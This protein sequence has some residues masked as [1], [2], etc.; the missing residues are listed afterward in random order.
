MTGK[1]KKPG[2]Y[3]WERPE[4]KH[5]WFR[6]TV[7]TRYRHVVGVAKIQ[8]SLGTSNLVDARRERDKLKDELISKWRELAGE[9]PTVST[10]IA[11]TTPHRPTR[12][13]VAQLEEAA[14]A[15]GYDLYLHDASARRLSL[16]SL[17]DW[18]FELA[19]ELAERDHHVQAM[20][21]ARGRITGVEELAKLA[22]AAM[23]FD[24][25]SGSDEYR[26]LCELIGQVR[27][28]STSVERKRLQGD[29]EAV[30]N[31]PLVSKVLARRSTIA[32]PG[33]RIMELFELWAEDR[34]REGRK[35][36]DTIVQDRKVIAR[37]AEFV[38]ADRSVDSIT[39]V[40]VAEFRDA[41]KKLPPKWMSK[42]EL[43]DLSMREAA[44]KA[45][46]LDLP[47]M[48][49]T[50]VNKYLSTIS[51]LYGWLVEQPRWAGLANP[52]RGLW[53]KGVKGQNRRPSF[54]SA[55]LN[56]I[57]QSPLF[58]GF[59][60]DGRE[61]LPGVQ[62]A[63][64]WRK[65]IPL[66]C[67]F[68]GAR[69]GEVAQA[70]VGDIRSQNGKWFFWIRHNLAEAMSTKS[71]LDRVVPM[72]SLL[73]RMGFLEF[74]EQRR[75]QSNDD[76]DAPLFPDL[77]PDSRGFIGGDPSEWWRDYLTA[78]GLKVGADGIGAHSF[79]HTITDRLRTEAELLDVE[80]AVCLGHDQKTTTGGYGSIPQGT[81]RMLSG[82]IE[83]VTFEGVSFDHLLIEATEEVDPEPPRLPSGKPSRADTK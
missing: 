3:L 42:R 75:R 25:P 18:G 53:A 14:V 60:S 83:A 70:R 32:E 59:E 23:G 82:W 37:F 56:A 2:K 50:N 43:R 78:I 51:P 11:R 22:I 12:P 5:I 65:W 72:H 71:K 16:S 1:K 17:G 27:F 57:L 13:T 64:D 35:R 4:S 49:L 67:M 48:K 52:C 21:N 15:V 76:G 63:N 26:I 40:E 39:P 33:E 45:R 79:R 19:A 61:H 54:S 62:R 80:I 31:S 7:P 47:K 69:I 73:R 77:A 36:A 41:L 29:L 38:G 74:H 81:A 66:L 44:E 68:T 20:E 58:I 6:M 28:S 10:D 24:A 30:G 46:Q 8:Q 9:G 55:A 34:R